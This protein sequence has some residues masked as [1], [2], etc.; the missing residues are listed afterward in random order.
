MSTVFFWEASHSETSNDGLDWGT[1]QPVGSV[2]PPGKRPGIARKPL[3]RARGRQLLC[4]PI[5]GCDGRK[6]QETHFSGDSL[7]GFETRHIRAG[8]RKRE[9]TL[10][11][12]RVIVRPFH[13]SSSNSRSACAAAA[14]SASAP[15]PTV[16][17]APAANRITLVMAT[18]LWSALSL[19]ATPE[20]RESSPGCKQGALYLPSECHVRPPQSNF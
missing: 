7:A 1:F 13:G 18:S 17:I 6:T 8:S 15:A 4:R 19:R 2:I 11:A 14:H 10:A 5:G 9:S 12:G 16:R 3:G 20:R